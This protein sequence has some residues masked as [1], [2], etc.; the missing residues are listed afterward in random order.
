LGTKIE[1]INKNQIAGFAQLVIEG[2]SVHGFAYLQHHNIPLSFNFFFA[3][4][5][6][7][8][9]WL[10]LLENDLQDHLR[11]QVIERALP[12]WSYCC[13]GV[14]V[15]EQTFLYSLVVPPE[16]WQVQQFWPL[17]S[18]SSFPQDKRERAIKRVMSFMV[19]FFYG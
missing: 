15:S 19:L 12:F 1:L 14:S 17:F 4:I 18:T 5:A 7:V 6:G 9:V 8:F 11:W 16:T 2:D 3:V 10:I 13:G